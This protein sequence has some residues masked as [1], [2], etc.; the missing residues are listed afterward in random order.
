MTTGEAI[1]ALYLLSEKVASGALG[2]YDGESVEAIDLAISALL[3]IKQERSE[4]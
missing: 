1:D 3:V 4:E 2:Y